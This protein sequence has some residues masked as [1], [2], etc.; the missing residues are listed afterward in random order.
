MEGK[1][2][3][4]DSAYNNFTLICPADH[5]RAVLS[6]STVYLYFIL[7]SE[8]IFKKFQKDPEDPPAFL[9]RRS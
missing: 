7:R 9:K 3:V 6:S 2:L 8:K 1:N 5:I 4:D